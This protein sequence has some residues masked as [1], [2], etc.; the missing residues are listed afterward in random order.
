MKIR[1][2]HLALSVVMFIALIATS[3]FADPNVTL[4]KPVTLNG[5]FGVLPDGSGWDPTQPLGSAGSVVDGIFF[6]EGTLWNQGSVW[7]NS[8]VSGSGSNSIVIDLQGAYHITGIIVQAD[9]NDG[10]AIDYFSPVTSAWTNF[11]AATAVPGWGLVTRPNADQVTPLPI[12]YDLYASRFR[13]SAFFVNDYDYAISEFQA[14]GTPVPEP[15][16]MLLLGLG[17]MGLA[18]VRR[19]SR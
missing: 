6:P 10:Y 9:N 11:G 14:F 12:F 18:G 19:F 7:W 17:L 13:L 15:A 8:T 3:A 4:N 5:V 1:K 16:T 2:I